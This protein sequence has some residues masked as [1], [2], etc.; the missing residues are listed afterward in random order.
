MLAGVPGFEPGLS[1][2]ETDVLAV[3][4]IPLWTFPIADLRLPIYAD[5]TNKLKIGNWQ[6]EMSLRFLM[7]RVLTAA[8][9]ELLELQTIWSGF[10]VLRRYVIAALAIAALQ[11]NVIA[12]HISFPISDCQ[13]PILSRLIHCSRIPIG[14]RQLEIGD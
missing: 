5:L 6:S 10:L 7:I 9:A 2:L 13:F 12:W 8:P 4:T 14:N 3:D 11:Y 1:V